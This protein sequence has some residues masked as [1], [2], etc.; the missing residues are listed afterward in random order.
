MLSKRYQRYEIIRKVEYF[1][2]HL[3]EGWKQYASTSKEQLRSATIIFE[4]MGKV[5]GMLSSLLKTMKNNKPKPSADAEPS[6]D[7]DI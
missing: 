5:R 2:K 3:V 6:E 1:I 7:A 4:S